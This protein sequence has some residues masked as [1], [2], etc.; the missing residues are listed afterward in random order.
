MDSISDTTDI[1]KMNP[2]IIKIKMPDQDRNDFE[3]C[4]QFFLEN[5]YKENSEELL[6]VSSLVSVDRLDHVL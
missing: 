1:Q 5:I 6:L 3:K 4:I 2:H